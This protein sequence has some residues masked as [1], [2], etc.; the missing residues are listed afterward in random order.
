MEQALMQLRKRAQNKYSK[1][2]AKVKE[3][4][5]RSREVTERPGS[6]RKAWME[7]VKLK[8]ELKEEWRDRVKRRKELK[9]KVQ[10]LRSSKKE[11]KEAVLEEVEEEEERALTDGTG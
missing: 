9:K 11:M 8:R 1:A 3:L 7:A 6:L 2:H 4:E 10:E 5:E